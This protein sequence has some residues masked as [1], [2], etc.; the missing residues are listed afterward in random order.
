MP[1]AEAA[2]SLKFSLKILQRPTYQTSE[3]DNPTD[4]SKPDPDVAS[5]LV[6]EAV[7][8]AAHRPIRSG[9]AE[10]RPRTFRGPEEK[11][12]RVSSAPTWSPLYRHARKKL[13]VEILESLPLLPKGKR[14][15]SYGSGGT[16]GNDRHSLRT[17]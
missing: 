3:T 12:A 17:V 8:D 1:A 16:P 6:H 7:T 14:G 10:F 15:L 11:Q 2:F 9:P 4:F 13:P 5:S